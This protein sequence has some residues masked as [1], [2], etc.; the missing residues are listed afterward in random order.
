MDTK[1]CTHCGETKPIT[2][3]WRK[4]AGRNGFQAACKICSGS[5]V[6]ASRMKQTKNLLANGVKRCTGCK[7]TKS[8]LDFPRNRNCA[9]GLHY[10]CKTCQARDH[11]RY[12]SSVDGA[13]RIAVKQ[14]ARWGEPKTRERYYDQK[15]RKKYG[16]PATWTYAGALALQNGGCA[17]CGK[18]HNPG[19]FRLAIDHDAKTGLV[20]GLL[21][22]HCNQALGQLQDS[23]ELLRKAADYLENPPAAHLNLTSAFKQKSKRRPLLV[24]SP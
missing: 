23:P 20:R 21:C 22:T 14:R 3:F 15:K 1:T 12:R 17:I 2:E 4:T 24:T 16:L 9:D 5:V 10:R 18:D 19:M 11:Q 6:G 13:E 8:A 7:E